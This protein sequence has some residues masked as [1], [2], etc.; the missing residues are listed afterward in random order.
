LWRGNRRKNLLLLFGALWRG[1]EQAAR[2]VSD[3]QRDG[4]AR[5]HYC[6]GLLLQDPQSEKT[7]S[8]FF[9]FLFCFFV[10]FVVFLFL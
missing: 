10:F 4:G 5:Q 1:G 2:L 7:S 8:Q 3:E 6:D 9:L